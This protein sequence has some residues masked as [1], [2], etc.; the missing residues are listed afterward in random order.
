MVIIICFYLLFDKL[1]CDNL[2]L[3]PGPTP[4]WELPK[5][6]TKM[7]ASPQMSSIRNALP[8]IERADRTT[9]RNVKL[10]LI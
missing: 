9:E 4:S 6:T 2:F 7:S 3:E 8:K 5:Q 1:Y 10:Q